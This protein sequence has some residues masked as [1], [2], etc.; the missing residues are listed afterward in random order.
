MNSFLDQ[1]S[2][3]RHADVVGVYLFEFVTSHVVLLAFCIYYW[4]GTLCI[5]FRHCVCLSF[6]LNNFST[7]TTTNKQT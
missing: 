3:T 1:Q 5:V 6:L 4:V 2:I 7:T